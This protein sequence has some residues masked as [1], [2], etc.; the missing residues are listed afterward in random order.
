[1]S[2]IGIAWVIILV[3]KL[4]GLAFVTASWWIIIFWPIVPLIILIVLGL[5]G[6]TAFSLTGK[7]YHR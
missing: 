7:S 1:M 2:L 6:L 3:L 4:A 5:V